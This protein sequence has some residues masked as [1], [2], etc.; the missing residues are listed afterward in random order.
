MIITCESCG[1][2]K[3]FRIKSQEECDKLFNNFQCENNC[4]RNL[5]SFITIGSLERENYRVPKMDLQYA[6]AK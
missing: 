6:V 3:K 2:V 5:L 4:G 1:T